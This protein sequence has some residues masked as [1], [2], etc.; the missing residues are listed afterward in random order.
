MTQS[1]DNNVDHGDLTHNRDIGDDVQR[2]FKYQHGYGV[3]L[4]CGMFTGT[5]PYSALICEEEDDYRGVE[6]EYSDFFQVK[7][8]APHTQKWQLKSPDFQSAI[9]RFCH[10]IERFGS[11]SR[12][13]FFVSNLE[14]YDTTAEK[15]IKHSPAALIRSVQSVKSSKQ[16]PPPFGGIFEN[17]CKDLKVESD[18]LFGV[19]TKLEFQKGPSIDDFEA[20]ISSS[21]IANISECE[22]LSGS[23]QNGIRDELLQVVFD[24]SSLTL[25]DSSKYEP[26]VGPHAENALQK[27]KRLTCSVVR[28]AILRGPQPAFRYSEF[29]SDMLLRI[30]SGDLTTLEKKLLR[31]DLSDQ[32]QTMRRRAISAERTLMERAMS[33][34]GKIKEIVNQLEVTVQGVCDDA[35]LAARRNGNIDGPEMLKYVNAELKRRTTLPSETVFQE[36]SDFLVGIAGLLS[37]ACTVWWSP[38]IDLN[39]D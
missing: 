12:K 16:L 27:A 18:I 19:L 10:H 23:V 14:L 5:I 20:V 21:H 22:G 1:Q 33:D 30:T 29:G 7:T 37:E 31:G 34:A 32:I 3:I 8:K 26:P 39:V 9:K 28:D 36:S 2:R 11:K 38:R 35:A 13:F 6:G 24:A 4:L 25:N 15:R 17:L